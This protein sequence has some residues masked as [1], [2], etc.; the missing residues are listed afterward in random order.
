MDRHRYTA[1]PE[2]YFCC[3]FATIVFS[4]LF[5]GISAKANSEASENCIIDRYDGKTYIF[6]EGGVEF[7]VFA[8][9]QF[10]FAYVGLNHGSD[11]NVNVNS[12][13]VNISFN[14][15]HDYEMFVQYEDYG[16]VIQVEDVPIYYDGYGRITQAGDVDIRYNNRRIVRV[17]GLYVHYNN[18]GNYISCTGFINSYNQFYVYRPWHIF[19]TRPNY[20]SCLVYD[21]QY[22]RYYSPVRYSYRHHRNY[23]RNGYRNARRVFQR[24]GSRVPY[25]NRRTAVNRSYRANRRNTTVS[26]RDRGNKS[27]RVA[28]TGN[29]GNRGTVKK[30]RPISKRGTA[31]RG[32]RN[33]SVT[34]RG[35]SKKVNRATH[36][37]KKNS[38]VAQNNGNRKINRS[39]TSRSSNTKMAKR[40]TTSRSNTSGKR[41]GTTKSRTT[42][43]RGRGL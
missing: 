4:F 21:Y 34:K 41:E 8:D 12:P 33:G 36:P 32:D 16:A 2:N 7:S 35:D 30:G 39:T 18:Y 22:R 38:R 1:A 27:S 10:D 19:Y 17:G 31:N 25:R 6:E 24:P 11:V 14:S 37:Q 3:H 15:G 9:G 28:K 26:N 40:T 23:Y 29:R 43:K 20:T 42:S 5:I 13:N